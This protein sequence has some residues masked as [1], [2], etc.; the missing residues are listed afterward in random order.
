MSRLVNSELVETAS[1]LYEKGFNI[2]PVGA[3]KRPLCEWSSRE[4]IPR[5]ELEKLLDKARGIAI[6]GGAENPWKPMFSLV[7]IDIDDPSVLNKSQTLSFI[8]ESTVAWKT[9]P[10]CPRCFNKHLELVEHGK[11]FKCGECGKEFTIEEAKRGIG[12][13]ITVD[14]DT[15]NKYFKGTVRAGSIEFLVNNYA[16]IPPS[17]HPTGTK[18]EWIK[19]FKLE[20]ANLGV[21]PLV[22]VEVEKL[23]EELGIFKP[24]LDATE[25]VEVLKTTRE[26][27]PLEN[28]VIIKIKEMLKPVYR[29]GN[30]QHI[31]LYL[32]G[33]AAKARISP[34]STAEI[35]K[36]LYDDLNDEDPMKMRAATLIYSYKKAG[37]DLTPYTSEIEKIFGISPR[38]L[39]KEISEEEVKGK[40]GLQEIF[41]GVL[42]ENRGL[43]AISE[44]EEELERTEYSE[45]GKEEPETTLHDK[46]SEVAERLPELIHK[47]CS[48]KIARFVKLNRTEKKAACI[49]NVISSQFKIV[50]VSPG[51]ASG[52]SVLYAALGNIL[53]DIDEVVKPVV[54]ALIARNAARRNLVNEVITAAYSTNCNVSYNK[55]NPWNYIR[56]DNGV[57]D[58]EALRVLDSTD[59]YFT[60]RLPVKI[61]QE[62][63]DLIVSDRYNIE[64]NQVYKYWKS[65]FDAENW[66][67]LVSS[68]GT[69]LAPFRSKHIAFLIGPSNSGKSTLLK[70]L[71]RPI[72][73][74]VANLSLGL[75]T[76]YTFG[77]EPLIG[78]QIAVYSERGETI[79]KRLDVINNLFGEQDYIT[80]PRKHKPSVV[81]SS[82][83]AGLFIMND[84]PIVYEYGGETMGAFLNRLS[85]IQASLPENATLV[86]N[87]TIPNEEAFKFLL[88]CRVQL[89]RNNWIIKKMSEDKAV[90]YF[91]KSTNSAIQF[92]NDPNSVEFDPAATEKGTKL[93]DAYIRWCAEKGISPLGRN[94][95]YSLVSSKQPSYLKDKVIWFKGIRLR[96]NSHKIASSLM[97]SIEKYSV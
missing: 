64:E 54:G 89:E 43:E 5:E 81:I 40:S 44:I 95:F 97:T 31:W 77:L 29:P 21:R 41:K 87:L 8:V 73:P 37:I 92:L 23:L 52:E 50:K 69:W 93:Y 48:L 71:T 34:V 67:Y 30:R 39:E 65:R 59:Y 4:R 45:I 58:L 15:A 55:I 88:W 13:L 47:C 49:Y 17:E 36:K 9:G 61:R 90:D 22:E 94:N 57:L 14:N 76:G 70:N 80:V 86:R 12:A 24:Q 42:G 33:W 2:V 60:Y 46:L 11:K 85:I 84:P 91:M 25:T 10:R 68:L 26:L 83:K 1:K 66:E 20:D 72:A 32:S 35:L 75:I 56:L 53:Y 18:Y 78:K 51:D 79:L 63:I 16:L 3:D 7:I 38:D 96:E 6:V 19:P 74:I 28:S 82:L 27:R 62:E